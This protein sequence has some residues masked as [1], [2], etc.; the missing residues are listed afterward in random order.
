VVFS[1]VIAVKV[2]LIGVFQQ[3]QPVIEYLRRGIG[4]PLDPVEY[5]SVDVPAF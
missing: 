3:T 2:L 4:V 1:D 5:P